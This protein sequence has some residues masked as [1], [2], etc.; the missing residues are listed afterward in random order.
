MDVAEV[1]NH[2]VPLYNSETGKNLPKEGLAETFS[3]LVQQKREEYYVKIKTGTTEPSYQIGAGS[4]TEKQWKK[5]LEGFDAAEDALRKAAGLEERRKTPKEHKSQENK[6]PDYLNVYE[7]DASIDR[8]AA[9]ET[10][11]CQSCLISPALMM[12]ARY[13]KAQ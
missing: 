12:P 9:Q 2:K 5:L 4:Y 13:R 8:D 6:R 10:H 11:V 1:Q 7:D 3:Q